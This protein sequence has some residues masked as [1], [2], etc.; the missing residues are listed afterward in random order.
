MTLLT[1][2]KKSTKTAGSL[3]RFRFPDRRVN[4]KVWRIACIVVG[5]AGLLLSRHYTGYGADLLH[6]HGAN[7]SFS[8]AA[9]FLLRFFNL[10]P[11][12]SRS[13][14][15]VYAMVVVSAQELAQ[16]YGYYPGVFDE[17]DL[18][19]NAAGISLA[20]GL[21]TFRAFAQ[22]QNALK[23]ENRSTKHRTGS[24]G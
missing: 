13:S 11:R 2:S 8:F 10:P 9:Y 18:L 3:S 15:A 22:R 21:D 7:V 14:A 1:P 20:V 16:G 19:F 4:E 12:D 17:W 5:V 23:L 24:S 6:A